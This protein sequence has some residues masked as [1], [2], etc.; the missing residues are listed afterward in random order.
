M[1]LDE[2]SLAMSS[3]TEVYLGCV[4]RGVLDDA[5]IEAIDQN[6]DALR[7]LLEAV[8]GA[9]A[10]TSNARACWP[11]VDFPAVAVWPMDV[12]SLLVPPVGDSG[13]AADALFA[14][15]LEESSW[16][17][18]GGCQAGPMCPH[19]GSRELLARERE[20][21]NLRNILRWY[22]VASGKRWS[23]RDLFSVTSYF[24]AGHRPDAANLSPCSLAERLVKLDEQAKR[25]A[26]PTKE[27]STALFHLVAA[28]Y[29]HAMFHSWDHSLAGRLLRDLKDLELRDDNTAM[30]L[31]WFISSRR[32]PYLPSMIAASLE[33]A[34][35]IMDPALADPDHEF[36]LTQRTSIRFRDLDLRFSRSV[37][38]GVDFIRR[39][40]VLQR[41]EIEL[42]DRLA[43]L[44]ADASRA[45]M[46]RRRPQAAGRVQRLVRDFASRLVRRSLGTRVGMVR[47][48]LVL[49]EF[50]R[51]TDSGDDDDLYDVAHE[52]EELLNSNQQFQVS[53][54]TT[55]GQ[56]M[57][58]ARYRALLVVPARRVKAIFH[59]A[60]DRPKSPV[61]FLS[62]GSGS[63]TRSIALTFDLFKAVREVDEGMSIAS[64]P[65]SVS[66][67]LDSTR[68]RL[69]GPIVR[70]PEILDRAA[71]RIGTGGVA[72]EERRDRFASIKGGSRR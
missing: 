17:P 29:Q 19:C 35:E 14:V 50:E 69:A 46:R 62:V 48:C 72:V 43:E 61:V 1:L 27:A 24:L 28:Q 63:S 30:G 54:T 2:L 49:R 71:I 13:S 44:D 55:F 31:Y 6:R 3:E 34:A 41:L 56:P 12:E 70:D 16:A 52:V 51:I 11:L 25:K 58:P 68:A 39:L 18:A 67:L 10:M 38:E 37:R 9:V 7:T 42:L 20:L 5:L 26:K 60:V 8:T 47:D 23:F 22:E 59:P 65:R 21:T 57:P 64:L 45:S 40:Q 4:N 15:A 32:S 36:Q 66:A 53:L 33:D